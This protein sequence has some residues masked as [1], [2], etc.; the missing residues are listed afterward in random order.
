MAG[1][2]AVRPPGDRVGG[3]LPTVQ[4]NGVVWTQAIVGNTVYV[5]GS[6]TTARPAGSSANQNNVARSNFLAYDLTTGQLRADIN[7]PANQQVRVIKASTDG[8]RIY[9][10]GDF[11][12]FGGQTRN[13]LAVVNTATNTLVAG[14]P[15]VDYHVHDIDLAGNTL[16]LGGNFGAV[17]GQTRGR[18]AALNATTGALLSWAPSVP[19]RE[20]F[21]IAAS[22]DGSQLAIGGPFETVNGVSNFGRGFA[23][24]STSTGEIMPF[25]ST[26]YVRNGGPDGAIMSLETD[27]DLL[28]GSGYTFGRNAGTLEGVFAAEWGAGALRWVNDCTGHPRGRPVG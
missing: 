26:Q 27:G 7:L 15:G 4:I 24:L 5:G 9:V 8:S 12:S 21:A 1:P 23:V 2:S 10:G 6:F 20:V 14:F 18:L 16:Y 13:R 3:A 22:P 19:D 17:G 25:A 11:T 28:Y